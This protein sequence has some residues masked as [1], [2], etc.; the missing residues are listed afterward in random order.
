VNAADAKAAQ[1]F[2]LAHELTHIWLGQ[3]WVSDVQIGSDNR[4][5]RFCNLVAAELF[6]PMAEFK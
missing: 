4:V 6:V 3:S 5:E 2:T 1:M